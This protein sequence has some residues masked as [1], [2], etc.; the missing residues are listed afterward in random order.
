MVGEAG[1]GEKELRNWL[2]LSVIYVRH[3]KTI[4]YIHKFN[5]IGNLSNLTLV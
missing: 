4:L 5:L 3:K 2:L 1:L